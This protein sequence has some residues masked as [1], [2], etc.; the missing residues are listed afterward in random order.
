MFA[1]SACVEVV[2]EIRITAEDRPVIR[3]D[4][5][6]RDFIE[7]GPA[8]AATIPTFPRNGKRKRDG[9]CVLREEAP[10][11]GLPL[12]SR[13]LP[14][15]SPRRMTVSQ[16]ASGRKSGRPRQ[17]FG[18]LRT[19]DAVPGSS[20]PPCKLTFRPPNT[21]KS[22]KQNPNCRSVLL[23]SYAAVPFALCSSAWCLVAS[24]VWCTAWSPCPAAISE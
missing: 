16:T 4:L 11:S 12:L 1:K 15:G 21:T 20:S 23:L 6:R 8:V 2:G 19:N 14:W 7:A 18:R 9:V 22:R 5:I 3:R 24:S 17:L 10:R 13:L